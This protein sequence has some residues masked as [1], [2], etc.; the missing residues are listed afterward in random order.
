MLRKDAREPV[1][2]QR[3]SV[4]T[5]DSNVR[6]RLGLV[7]RHVRRLT[8]RFLIDRCRNVLSLEAH[9]QHHHRRDRLQLDEGVRAVG[10]GG[11]AQVGVAL[12]VALKEGDV[13]EGVLAE[14]LLADGQIGRRSR[15]GSGS[16]RGGNKLRQRRIA[17]DKRLLGRRAL[18]TAAL[19]VIIVAAALEEALGA[20]VHM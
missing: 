17:N 19:L 14:N 3:V 1:R 12:D 20:G 2:R 4:A 10:V 7:H 6:L 18:A 13:R 9:A 5:Y 16:G 11:V 15:S 8:V